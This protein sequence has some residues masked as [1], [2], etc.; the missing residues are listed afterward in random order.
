[1]PDELDH[2][3]RPALPW[4]DDALTECGL[5]AAKFVTLTVDEFV[6]KVGRQGRQRA[7]MSTCMTCWSTA[8]RWYHRGQHGSAEVKFLDT[9]GREIERCRWGRAAGEDRV[10]LAAEFRA[11]GLLIEAHREEFDAAVAGIAGT[12]KLSDVRAKKQ[13]E[14]RQ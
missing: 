3:R 2:V 7:S 8:E 14:G 6:A 5:P 4:R 1:M 13:W 11:I 10:R 9:I 12:P